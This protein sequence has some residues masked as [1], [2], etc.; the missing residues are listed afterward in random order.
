MVADAW[1][2]SSVVYQIYPRSF[3]DSNGDGIGDIPGIRRRLGYLQ[4]LG[5]DAVWLS[6]VYPSPMADF[7][8]DITD[9]RDVDPI[10]GSLSDL[11]GLVDD[12]HAAGIKVILDYVPNHTSSQHPW[13]IESRASKASPK[14]DWYV[15]RGASRDGGPPNNWIS[16]FGGDAWEW[17]AAT[18]QY[19]Y[20]AFLPEQPDLNWRSP[21][22]RREML[23]V[24][25]YWL[26][27]GVDGFRVD[28]LW[29]LIEDDRLRDNPPNPTWRRGEPASGRLLPLYNG[30]RPEVHDAV[31]E[32]RATLDEYPERV[33]IGELYLPFDRLA[34]YYGAEARGAHLPFNFHLITAEWR[35][36][37]LAKLIKDYEAALPPGAWPNWVLGNHDQK[38]IAS[39][40]G[41][42]RARLAAMALLTLRGTPTLYYG[43]E[44]GMPHGR[45]PPGRVQDPLGRREP[46]RG[47]DPERTPMAWDA[48]AHGGFTTGTPWLP[49]HPDR[50][51]RNVAAMSD[52]PRSILTLYRR[53]IALRRER[54]ALQTGPYRRIGFE[55]GCLVLER[56]REGAERIIVALNLVDEPASLA[57]PSP[58]R[59]LLSSW[60]DRD[61]ERV[62]GEIALRPSEGVILSAEDQ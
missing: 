21:A 61:S 33:L 22:V 23:D 56:G 39:R 15:W 2:R 36:E 8:Y 60:L 50:T 7:G 17:D 24:L 9:Y 19:Y 12:A 3:Q 59:V 32:M 14:R 30:D 57:L 25:H 44:I 13:F 48:S 11:K 1:W 5:V 53:L 34:L 46:G 49:V 43:D 18:S 62:D 51:T 42:T 37:A 45:I 6:P 16:L 20:H 31:A 4:W 35:A 27:L 52:D 58:S 47:R 29:A 26:D 40:L 41:Q 10:F 28:A 38:R 54:K 55:G